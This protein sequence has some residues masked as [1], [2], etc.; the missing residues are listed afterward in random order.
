MRQNT[1]RIQLAYSA[2]ILIWT[3]AGCHAS[4]RRLNNTRVFVGCVGSVEYTGCSTHAY[5]RN[6]NDSDPFQGL[7]N[8]QCFQSYKRAMGR[9]KL[10]SFC[11][12]VF[13]V[14]STTDNERGAAVHTKRPFLFVF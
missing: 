5:T 6:R 11:F 14:T 12:N 9:W 10:F 13:E 3:V 7:F 1:W 2:V 8:I 4:E